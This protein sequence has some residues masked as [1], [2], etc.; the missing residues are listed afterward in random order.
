MNAEQ[1][2]VRLSDVI[3]IVCII[4]AILC[5]IPTIVF[6]DTS[7]DAYLYSFPL[8]IVA[9]AFSFYRGRIL[10][11]LISFVMIFSFGL[12]WIIAIVVVEHNEIKLHESISA[13]SGT[14]ILKRREIFEI[15]DENSENISFI[16]FGRSSCFPCKMFE[17]VLKEAIDMAG[18]TVYYY[19]TEKNQQLEVDVI[20]ERLKVPH[21]PFLIAV[22]KGKVIKSTS[23]A[24]IEELYV[25]FD[26]M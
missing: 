12:Y 6:G 2:S 26:I 1:K 9:L 10:M 3:V 23:S 5:W 16:Y 4:L 8:G 21:V 15:I 24:I 11:I 20:L 18:V 25:V 7:S 14:T 22:S 17:P 13:P 19:D